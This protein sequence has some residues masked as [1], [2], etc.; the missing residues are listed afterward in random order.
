MELIRNISILIIK[1][2]LGLII[3]SSSNACDEVSAQKSDLNR[4][5]EFTASDFEPAISLK[6]TELNLQNHMGDISDFHLVEN[7]Y[8]I[9][10]GIFEGYRCHLYDL[11]TGKLTHFGKD[12]RGPGELLTVFSYDY[13]AKD[14]SIWVQDIK[15]KIWNSYSLDSLISGNPDKASLEQMELDLYGFQYPIWIDD[16]KIAAISN[17]DNSARFFFLNA[18]NVVKDKVGTIPVKEDETWVDYVHAQI[19]QGM[20]SASPDR[21]NLVF[22]GRYFDEIRILS[23]DQNQEFQ[24]YGPGKVD[25]IWELLDIEGNQNFAINKHTTEATT[26]VSASNSSI[27]LLFSGRS[28]A[29][30]PKDEK[31]AG[32]W[33]SFSDQVF[34]LD[35]SGKPKAKYT[36]DR[37]VLNVVISSDEKYLYAIDY[38]KPDIVKYELSNML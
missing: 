27:Y 24:F 26:Q 12:G 11:E 22:A 9:Y 6:G 16:N 35:W 31:S 18:E 30:A 25:P 36:L 5:N 28:K 4:S 21:R 38:N 10:S 15:R 14:R 33:K 17:L 32:M 7:R 19:Y 34:V 23:L 3:V 13:R 29:M 37:E 8:L 2:V 20:L 1:I